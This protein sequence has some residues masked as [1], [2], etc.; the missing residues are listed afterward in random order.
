MVSPTGNVP[1]IIVDELGNQYAV[2]SDRFRFGSGNPSQELETDLPVN[3]SFTAEELDP[4]ATKAT[5]ILAG[6][7][8]NEG[9]FK[10][11]LRNIRIEQK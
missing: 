5:V 2:R 4:A 8:Q 9:N 1:P 3:F 10:V 7:V 6:W 11:T